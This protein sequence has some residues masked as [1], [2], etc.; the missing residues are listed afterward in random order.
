MVDLPEDQLRAIE[1]SAYMDEIG[2]LREG[3]LERTPA[4]AEILESPVRR[5]LLELVNHVVDEKKAVEFLE[6]LPEDIA[7]LRTTMVAGANGGV[8]NLIAT[9]GTVAITVTVARDPTIAARR[10]RLEML[11]AH[12]LAQR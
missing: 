4:L 1:L 5:R 2:V 6:A 9:L 8:G 11:G 12:E 3:L 7:I 10:R